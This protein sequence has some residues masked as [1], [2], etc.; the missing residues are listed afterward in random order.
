MEQMKS[1]N[2]FFRIL[3]AAGGFFKRFF[4]KVFGFIKKHKIISVIIIA[5]LVGGTVFAV[6]KI[7]NK[8]ADDAAS[9]NEA[10]ATRM[11]IAESITGSSTVE[12][13]DTYSVIPLVTGEILQA[14][15]EEGDTVTKDQVLYKIDSSSLETSVK[16]ANLNIEKAQIAY[17][18]ALGSHTDEIS[19]KTTESNNLSVQKA[20][21]SYDQALENAG[22]LTVTAGTSGTVSDVYVSVGDNVVNGT[23]VAEIN[24]NNRLKASIPFNAADVDYI[25][26]GDAASVTLVN[27]G[28]TINGVVTSVSSGSET[29]SGGMRIR[30]VT[31]EI[32]NPGSVMTGD[33]A[34]AMVGGYACNSVGTFEP[35][36]KRTVIAETSGEIT[37]VT[38]VKGDY[39]LE[40]STVATIKSTTVDNQTRDAELAL[41]EAKL[42]QESSKLEQLDADDY[43]A[44]LKTARLSLDSAILE[45][46]KLY[47]QLEDYTIKSPIDGTVVTKNKKQGDKIESGGGG[48]SAAASTS[49]SSTSSNVLA[50]IYDMSSLCIQ[51]DIDEL[52][53][54]KVAVGQEVEI[55]ADAVEGKTYSGVVE[56]VSVNGTI[57]TNGVTTY[58]AKVRIQDADEQLLPGMNV[59]AEITVEQADNVIAVPMNA[60]NRGDTVYVKGD[61][62]DQNDKAPEGYKTVSVETGINNGSFIEIKSG[63]NENDIVYVTPSAGDSQQEMMPGMGGMPGGGGMSGG[64]GAP[65]GGGMPGGGGGNRSGGG[66][67]GGGGR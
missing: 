38:V 43:S 27:S 50:V 19:D 66:M 13:N 21:N 44:K 14:D 30:Y 56:N 55:T 53:V 51:L 5:A 2:I 42:K 61:K 23:K 58:P 22:H 67:P 20:L 29:V 57:G 40:G 11:T 9:K 16:S 54:K 64:G 39:V 47:T 1:K 46:E 34:T 8:N 33:S 18:K 62:T 60:V 31:V 26:S 48:Q 7:K 12:A 15:F 17:N 63:L 28:S 37:S 49:S 4:K 10:E 24:N 32:D 3:S 6:G 45:R 59:D 35:A 36:E 65:G 41:R 25:A 52:D